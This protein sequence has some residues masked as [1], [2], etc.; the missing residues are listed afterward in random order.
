MDN[1]AIQHHDQMVFPVL[2]RH[3]L[4]LG[5]VVATQFRARAGC[6]VVIEVESIEPVQDSQGSVD[7]GGSNDTVIV[8]E[9]ELDFTSLN[10][11]SNPITFSH[12]NPLETNTNITF[13]IIIAK[14]YF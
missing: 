13:Y 7:M 10:F 14:F 5:H 12:F 6:P 9:G 1:G 8:A 4:D 11:T 2:Q 3:A